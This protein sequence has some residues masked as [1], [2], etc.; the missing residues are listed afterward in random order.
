MMARGLFLAILVATAISAD[1]CSRGGGGHGRTAPALGGSSGGSGAGSGSGPGGTSGAP[2]ATSAYSAF[3]A[4]LQALPS[5]SPSDQQARLDAFID[6]QQ[7]SLEGFPLRR[8]LDAIFVYR[9]PSAGPLAVAGEWNSWS[10]SARPLQRA[11]STNVWYAHE[12]LPF[13]GRYEYKIVEAGR[14]W[15]GDPLNRKFAY[16]FENAVLNTAGSAQ[17][18]LERLRGVRASR[19]GN[20]RDVVVYLPPGAL[21]AGERYPVLYMHDG[22]NLFDPGA[23]WG[24]WD[25]AG[26]LDRLIGQ[27]AIRKLIAV[28]IDNTPGRM[29]EYTHVP[30]DISA[31]CTGAVVGGRAPDYADFIVNELKPAID[32]LYP[33]RTGREDTAILGSSLGGLVS[34]WIGYAYPHVFR[35]V[36]GMSSTLD[37]GAFCLGNPTLTDIARA[38]GK[39]DFRIYIDSGGAGPSNPGEDNFG[40]TRELE[41]LLESQ[42]Y[43]HGVDLF[44]WWAPGAAHNE[45]SWRARLEL[46]LLFWF[47]R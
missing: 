33:T 2:A 26:T 12:R 30:D 13:A 10:T 28:G 18:H 35:D 22:Q 40:A 46:P 36:G 39:Q 27:G 29:D 47:K 17:S 9:G 16:G 8:G 41:I 43:A 44:H 23:P 38:A 34:L 15:L 21:D 4:L 6:A 32:A 1:A 20:R 31:R 37:W 7:K 45:A 19:L 42:G 3:E 14:N 11:G 25:V 24:G 5:L